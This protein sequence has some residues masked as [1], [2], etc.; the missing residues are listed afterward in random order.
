MSTE[1]STCTR[2]K[3]IL[4][5]DKFSV[6]RTGEI[7]KQC[8]DCIVKRTETRVNNYCPH[9]KQKSKCRL[10]GGSSYCEHDKIRCECLQCGGASYCI[11]KVIKGKC[12]ACKGSQICDHMKIRSQC[13][14]CNVQGCI[15][16]NIVNKM[17]DVIG[18]GDFDNVGCSM[19]ELI[20]HIESQFTDGMSLDNYG[21]WVISYIKRPTDKSLTLEEKIERFEFTNIKPIWTK[22]I[23]RHQK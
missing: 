18:Y 19:D 15:R 9:K 17:H 11:H 21:E 1:V 8:K 20:T 2:C 23:N 6:K 12:I 10:C 7:Y 14:D 16:K 5:L 13:C 4:S 3:K 22:D